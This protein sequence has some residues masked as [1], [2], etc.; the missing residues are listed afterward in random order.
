MYIKSNK[1]SILPLLAFLACISLL[2]C[3]K[4]E[5]DE[6]PV[7]GAGGGTGGNPTTAVPNKKIK[8]L[9]LLHVTTGGGFDVVAEDAIIEGTVVMDDKS[10][11]YYK[12]LV[13][14]DETG[15]IEVKFFDGYLF[16][17]YPLG[18]KL[19]I[20][21]KDLVLT[22]YK[23]L[24]QL[25]GSVVD[26]AGV[27]KIS[28]I[29]ADQALTHVFTGAI[30]LATPKTTTLGAINDAM[31]STL[32]QFDAVEFVATDLGKTFADA[33]AKTSASTNVEDC[34]SNTLVIRTSGYAD[35]AGTT[36]A[37]KKGKLTGVL[38][39]YNGT[40][41]LVLRNTDDVQMAD[42]RCTGG[43]GN[44]G[45]GGTNSG[46]IYNDLFED[47]ST[48]TNNVDLSLTDWTNIATAGTRIWRG[49]T[50]QATS[51][52]QSTAYNSNLADMTTWVITPNLNLK[53]QKTLDFETAM[54]YYKH[55]GLTVWVSNNFTGDAAAATW[56][57]LTSATIAGS[58]SG[59]NTWVP[60][61]V[62]QLPIYANGFGNIAFKY[63]GN[64]AANTTTY[65]I[66]NVNV[67]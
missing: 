30:A 26:V 32:L 48:I 10:G 1:F 31:I 23:G 45:G 18:M 13:I 34:S 46:T 22:D 25:G 7:T 4:T 39:V 12:T 29:T 20:K 36:V 42:P 16:N 9:K 43:G 14:Q 58:A 38:S 5:F 50:Y 41:Q 44:P 66:D 62:I 11:N 64:S 2:A 19:T 49:A 61:G 57:Q 15:G 47:F 3:V 35:F 24:V 37:D 55:D 54:A 6:P 65:R 17:T 27:K 28:G 56:T 67:Q 52:A 53:T 59:N 8:D 21:T 33:V 40:Y 51:Y 60:S 63:Q